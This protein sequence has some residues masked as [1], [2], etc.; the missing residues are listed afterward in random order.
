MFADMDRETMVCFKGTIKQ[1]PDGLFVFLMPIL[2]E[3]V[4]ASPTE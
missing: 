3:Y 1:R 2:F 4:K